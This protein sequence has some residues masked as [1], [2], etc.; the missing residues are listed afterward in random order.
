MCHWHCGHGGAAVPQLPLM[1]QPVCCRRP[2][3][4]QC[5]ARVTA[6]REP[7]WGRAA[8]AEHGRV[9]PWCPLNLALR[10]LL[11]HQPQR[12][13]HSG[14]LG[15]HMPCCL[16]WRSIRPA[17]LP[18][19]EVSV[20]QVQAPPPEHWGLLRVAPACS[21]RGSCRFCSPRG[22]AL[23][24][25]LVSHVTQTASDVCGAQPAPVCTC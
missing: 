15:E 9:W 25:S 24:W 21:Q 4:F 6:F 10:L 20:H 23:R 16:A 8:C 3:A 14:Q 13:I 2:Q 7:R 17:G 11:P 22:P 12:C 5:P 1:S 18:S 19:Q